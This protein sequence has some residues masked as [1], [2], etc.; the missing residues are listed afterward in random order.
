M[1]VSIHVNDVNVPVFWPG[2]GL[3]HIQQIVADLKPGVGVSTEV[4]PA[5]KGF[6]GRGVHDEEFEDVRLS[7]GDLQQ[8][9][10]VSD[11]FHLGDES[12]V[13]WN[14]FVIVEWV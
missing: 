8:E 3:W 6:H 10:G 13:V 7:V 2:V 11:P 12:L 1:V 5:E 9:P 14:V 4:R